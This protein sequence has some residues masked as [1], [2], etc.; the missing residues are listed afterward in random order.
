MNP[1]SYRSAVEVYADQGVDTEAALATLAA[2]PVS[3]QC[4]QGDDV[5]GFERPGATLGGGGIQVTGRYPGK[6]R[7]LDE[8]RSDLEGF[9]VRFGG[10]TLAVA[11]P[12]VSSVAEV[13]DMVEG[14][15]RAL[16]AV[17]V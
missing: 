12:F 1:T 17:P 5:G 9:L 14:L 15:R 7:T 6:A 8:L 10:E 4:W 11:P 16:R 3:L 2:T 13:E